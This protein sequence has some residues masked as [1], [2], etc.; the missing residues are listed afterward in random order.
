MEELIDQ[1]LSTR[2]I[3]KERA[4]GFATFF[5]GP[6]AAGYLFAENFKALNESEK[7]TKTWVIAIISS[8]VI[9]GGILLIPEDVHIPNHIIPIIYTFITL[10]IF[11]NLQEEK[12]TKYIENEGETYGW[13]RTIGVSVL[14]FT[15]SIAFLV[16]GIFSYSAILE[17]NYTSKTYGQEVQHQVRFNHTSI[18]EEEADNVAMG[19]FEMGFFDLTVSKEVSVERH[20]S[21]LEISIPITED[22]L[23]DNDVIDG[24]TA[25]RDFLDDYL[26]NDEVELKLV[27]DTWDNVA[28]TLNRQ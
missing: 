12:I 6:L 25:M 10:G 28:M 20:E 23:N 17:T 24:C 4:I 1:E 9:F 7:T 18:S 11:R 8:I 15:V 21:M 26:P 16:A 27:I 22:V 13:G 3:F 14:G 2:K 19:F 5:G